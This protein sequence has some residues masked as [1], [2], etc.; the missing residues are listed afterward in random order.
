[1]ISAMGA[2][3]LYDLRHAI[4]WWVAYFAVLFLSG[5]IA[6]FLRDTNNLPPPV[7]TVFFV[8]NIAGV[9]TI[10]LLMLTYFINQK[11]EAYRLLRLEQEKA[12]GLLLNILPEEIAARLKIENRTIADQY[13][14]ASILFADL[15]GF[16]PLSAEMSPVDVVNLLNEIFSYFDGLVEKYGVEKIRTIGDNYMVAAGVPRPQSDHARVLACMALDMR[17][18]LD[19]RPA[20]AGKRIEFRIGINSGPV[21]GGVIGRKKFVFDIWGDAVNI[22]SRME[23]QGLAGK[24]QITDHTHRLIQSSF[25]CEPRGRVVIKG[26]GEMKTWFLVGMKPERA[27]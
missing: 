1:M 26:R 21:V 3:F 8:M 16:T 14:G 22:A 6:P 9:S 24:I 27:T 11:N 23:S 7:N 10:V 5:L 13:E 4:G 18:Y 17:E 20:A 12:E 19:N 25:I 2:L 15:V